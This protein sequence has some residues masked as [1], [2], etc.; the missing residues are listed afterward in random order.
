M[1]VTISGRTKCQ[2][3]HQCERLPVEIQVL[4]IASPSSERCSSSSSASA[5]MLPR[6]PRP[7]P[8]GRPGVGKADVLFHQQNGAG[9]LS[10]ANAS[11][12]LLMMAGPV[13]CWVRHDEQV[14]RFNYGARHC[15]C[16]CPPDSLPAD[17]SRTSPP[18]E[19]VK[20]S[21]AAGYCQLV[22]CWLRVRPA[23]CSLTGSKKCPCF[24][25]RK[26]CLA[27][28]HAASRQP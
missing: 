16:F 13:P 22:G 8:H 2:Q 25:A 11:I 4:H 15:I 5:C 23:L 17:G 21:T 19:T 12:M 10:R 7:S 28:Q 14:A 6:A 9:F 24:R 1:E 18:Q 27:R 26:Q 3:W 20:R